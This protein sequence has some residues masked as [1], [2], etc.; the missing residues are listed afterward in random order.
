[1][2]RSYYI[3]GGDVSFLMVKERDFSESRINSKKKLASKVSIDEGWCV[4]VLKS[5]KEAR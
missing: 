1:M 2:R 4:M 5:S 3:R